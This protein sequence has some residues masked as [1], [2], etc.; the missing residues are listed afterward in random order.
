[1]SQRTKNQTNGTVLHVSAICPPVFWHQEWL[2]ERQVR[3]A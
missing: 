1:M 3:R 2:A